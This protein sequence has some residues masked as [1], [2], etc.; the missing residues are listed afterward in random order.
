MA[1]GV[2][3]SSFRRWVSGGINRPDHGYNRHVFC[4][5][6]FGDIYWAV[7]PKA[8]YTFNRL[9]TFT[10]RQVQENVLHQSSFLAIASLLVL[11]AIMSLSYGVSSALGDG[12]YAD[13]T[14]DI[15]LQGDQ[16]EIVKVM[17]SGEVSPY[18]Q[19]YYPMNLSNIGGPVYNEAGQIIEEEQKFSWFGLIEAI[20]TQPQS[21]ERNSLLRNLQPGSTPFLISLSSYNSLLESMKKEPINLNSSEM[22]FYISGSFGVY[23]DELQKAVM[24]NPEIML[25]GKTFTLVSEIQTPNLVAD[26][27]IT[28]LFAL[29]VPDDVYQE[30]IGDEPPFCWNVVLDPDFVQEQG[31][32]Q[33]LYQMD[34]L[35]QGTGLDYE[36]YLSGIGRQLFYIVAGSYLTLYL[37]ILFLIIANTVL[38]FKFLMQQRSTRHRYETLLILGANQEALV[39]SVKT[40][41]R[42]YF[43]L[44]VGVAVFSSI[45]ALRR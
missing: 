31:L 26:R 13:R 27:Y 24:T 37:G 19:G 30:V 5:P 1:Y 34:G 16:Q 15:S 21:S 2:G 25:E 6:G 28:I 10:G 35:L 32:M 40:Q 45:F 3:F 42:V 11:M 7:G 39:A 20:E 18:I 8:K 33:A 43:F 9:F 36:S 12:N 4:F 41:I 23:V 38:G 14:V 29:I 22:A 44:I 17:E